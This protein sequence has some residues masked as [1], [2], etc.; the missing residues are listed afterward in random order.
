MH[1]QQGK[2]IDSYFLVQLICCIPNATMCVRRSAWVVPFGH[3]CDNKWAR[4]PRL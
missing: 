3:P 1:A 4:T 2:A